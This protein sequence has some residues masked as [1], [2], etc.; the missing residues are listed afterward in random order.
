MFFYV[1]Y[2]L[3]LLDFVYANSIRKSVIFVVLITIIGIFINIV[4]NWSV[5]KSLDVVL[6]SM[7]KLESG[8]FSVR[9][10]KYKLFSPTPLMRFSDVFNKVAEELESIEM[11]RSDFV[12]TFSHQF[13]TPI[14][15][16]K[17]FANMLNEPGLSNEKREEY[18]GIIISESDRLAALATTVLNLSKIESHTVLTGQKQ[19]EIGEEVRQAILLLEQ[20]WTDKNLEIEINIDDVKAYGDDKLLKEVWLNILDNA[21]KFSKPDGRL[22]VQVV[23]HFES[24]EFSVQDFGC[25]MDAFSAKHVY[26]KFYQGDVSHSSSGFGIGMSVVKKIVDLHSGLITIDS[27]LGEGT[28]VTVK[29]PKRYAAKLV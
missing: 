29:L 17:G 15:S 20:K 14:V 27:V 11:L 26:D 19:F 12:N 9:I 22:I 5:S 24:V 13:K 7:K 4:S 10:D 25:G 16:I 23:D 3:D 8:D 21:V 1:L 28:A 18:V 2:R 6:E